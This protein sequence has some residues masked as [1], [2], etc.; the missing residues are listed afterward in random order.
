M[1]RS[2]EAGGAA[3]SEGDSAR[4]GAGMKDEGRGRFSGV[5]HVA[6]GPSD[7]LTR[8][9]ARL[10]AFAGDGFLSAA[11]A[12][13]GASGAAAVSAGAVFFPRG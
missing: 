4:G 7:E 13:R 2:D 11:L 1:S 10:G 9:L 6:T 5:S 3:T 8:A 12:V